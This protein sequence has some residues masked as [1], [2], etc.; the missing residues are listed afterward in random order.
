MK[1]WGSLKLA[2]RTVIMPQNIC[3]KWIKVNQK[4]KVC[5]DI[6]HIFSYCSSMKENLM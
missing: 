1:I 2:G 6:F 5:G 3:K 4:K